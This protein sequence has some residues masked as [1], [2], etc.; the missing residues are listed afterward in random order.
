MDGF[1]TFYSDPH[2]HT[3]VEFS[4]EDLCALEVNCDG[5]HYNIQGLITM[6]NIVH[7]GIS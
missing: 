1:V 7:H 4:W 3:K 2:G 6:E 5:Q